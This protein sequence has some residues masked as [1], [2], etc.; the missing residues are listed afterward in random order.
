MK[1]KFYTLAFILVAFAGFHHTKAQ[2]YVIDTVF[3]ADEDGNPATLRYIN[4]GAALW[5]GPH[6]KVY[7]NNDVVIRALAIYIHPSAQIIDTVTTGR[8]PK[9]V[10]DNPHNGIITTEFPY[11][12]FDGGNVTIPCPVLIATKYNVDLGK[13]IV[14]DNVWN[15]DFIPDPNTSNDM[16]LDD[17]LIFDVVD[18][19]AQPNPISNNHVIINNE[20][21]VFNAPARAIPSGYSNLV[22]GNRYIV[23][24]DT[25]YV[26]KK[27]LH[28]GDQFFFPI[29][30]AEMLPFVETV[31]N[32]C[33]I[34]QDDHL[35][36]ITDISAR[37]L[38]ITKLPAPIYFN[39]L[40][41]TVQRAWMVMNSSNRK[42]KIE[43]IHHQG[44]EAN[45]FNHFNSNIA[46]WDGATWTTSADDGE[47][48]NPAVGE[49]IA[50]GS[51][52]WM[53]DKSND[54]LSGD[55]AGNKAKIFFTKTTNGPIILPVVFGAFTIQNRNCTPELNWNTL[56][57]T[58]ADKFLIQHKNR[59]G[60][61]ENAGTVIA[62]GNSTIKQ[63]YSFIF[64]GEIIQGSN[65]FRIMLVNKDG[66]TAYSNEQ[67]VAMHC[68]TAS[69][70]VSPNPVA[71]GVSPTVILAGATSFDLF[72]TNGKKVRSTISSG[73]STQINMLHLPAG[74]YQLVAL[75]G[76]KK[77]AVKTILKK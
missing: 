45:A 16:V 36:L 48:N 17:S 42:L 47:I 14:P 63:E 29:G 3:N 53:Q 37:V 75:N 62:R 64:N 46:R 15:G 9:I 54:V 18:H 51:N 22:N 66:S 49:G 6:A 38:P 26:I 77:L 56:T 4:A 32:P 20:H 52:Y 23:T 34:T 61:W 72:D 55:I 19:A 28:Y 57:E 21:L 12:I 31:Y 60:N 2:N 40:A 50:G 1:Q 41:P 76:N 74:I 5:I 33:R 39:M 71:A 44:T 58:N 65:Y 10:I 67:V 27:G 8:N 69:I 73:T 70:S 43:A 35:N 11:T 7:I 24:N 25:G 59:S 13:L 68:N 30:I